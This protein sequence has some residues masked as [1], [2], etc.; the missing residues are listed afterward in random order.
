MISSFEQVILLFLLFL[1]SLMKELAAGN[2]SA[3]SDFEISTW[4]SLYL[5]M[6]GRV[7]LQPFQHMWVSLLVDV[8]MIL[9]GSVAIICRNVS[10]EIS[11][12]SIGTGES[13]F[14]IEV[15]QCSAPI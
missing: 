5:T 7:L 15:M 12:I 6:W 11:T 14:Q 9:L 2:I 8:K 13:N 10:I 3:E 1:E 4:G